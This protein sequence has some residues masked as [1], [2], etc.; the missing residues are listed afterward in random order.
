MQLDKT[1][2]GDFISRLRSH[3]RGEQVHYHCTRDHLF[4][5]QKRVRH[6]GIDLKYD[7]QTI[8][9]LSDD[10]ELEYETYEELR[11]AATEY[12]TENECS[13]D[14]WDFRFDDE[15]TLNGKTVFEKIGY[16][17]T[18]DYVCAHFTKEAAEAFISRKKHDYDKLR[19]YV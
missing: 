15:I 2:F 7:P 11:D 17:E 19:V 6:Y 9:V 13:L 10:K 5:V 3:N 4:I 8:W 14:E 12:E 1:T 16:I 18:W